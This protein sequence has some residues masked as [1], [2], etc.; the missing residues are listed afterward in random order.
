MWT[1]PECGGSLWERG[2]GTALEYRCHVG[3]AWGAESLAYAQDDR[4]EDAMWTAYRIL[5]ENAAL[6]RRLA[7][8]AERSDNGPLAR[9]YWRRHDEARARAALIHRVL[10]RG[11]LSSGEA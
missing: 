9:R 11:A 6:S 2:A 10:E 7:E 3:H 5:E 4:V 8:R 1:C